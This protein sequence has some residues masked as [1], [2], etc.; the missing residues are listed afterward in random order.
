[1]RPAE[2]TRRHT[3]LLK[4]TS[5]FAPPPPQRLPCALLPTRVCGQIL[6]RQAV[7]PPDEEAYPENPGR[8]EKEE[9]KK[10]DGASTRLSLHR[11]QA[12]PVDEEDIE[13]PIG[14]EVLCCAFSGDGEFFAVGA[15]DGVVRVYNDST[16]VR[17]ISKKTC[18]GGVG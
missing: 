1:M 5:P 4:Y 11:E 14:V 15:S 16:R 12:K 2:V 6:H 3:A 7:P 17:K 8:E 10:E 13:I 18:V 9:Q